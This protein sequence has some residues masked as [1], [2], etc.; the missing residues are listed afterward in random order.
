MLV[1]RCVGREQGGGGVLAQRIRHGA[2]SSSVGVAHHGEK[3]VFRSILELGRTFGFR[4]RR[5]CRRPRKALEQCNEAGRI[6]EGRN[7]TVVSGTAAVF[8]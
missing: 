5:R 3:S 4:D 1:S 8:F 6:R 7:D 2:G